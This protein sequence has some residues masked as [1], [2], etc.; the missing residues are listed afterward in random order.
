M[1]FIA[2]FY[3]GLIQAG[4]GLFYYSYIDKLKRH[5]QAEQREDLAVL[6]LAKQSLRRHFKAFLFV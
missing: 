6:A 1:L 5:L 3:G 4:V 2:R